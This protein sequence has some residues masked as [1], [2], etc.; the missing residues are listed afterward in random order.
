[1]KR[2]ILILIAV[3]SAVFINAAN[4]EKQYNK[5]IEIYDIADEAKEVAPMNTAA[6]WRAMLDN[7]ESCLKFLKDIKKNK[8]AEK[9][10]LNNTAQ[11]P[12][13]YPQYD[14]TIVGDL[15]GFC[16]T[17]LI[18]MGI[19]DLGIKCSLHV[20]SSDEAYAFTALTEDGFAMCLTTRLINKKGVTYETLMGYVAREFVHGALYH[21]TRGFYAQAK[22]DRKYAIIG[23]LAAGALVTTLALTADDQDHCHHRTYDSNCDTTVVNIENVTDLSARK[24]SFQYT[25]DQEFEAD[26][27]AYRFLEYLGNSDEFINGLRILGADYDAFYGENSNHPTIVTRID[28]L[29]Y[30]RKHPELGNTK[31]AKLR[32][33]R[34]QSEQS[35]R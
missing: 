5:I 24:Y 18:D 1:M 21:H 2:I 14:E 3:T 29:K 19:S 13:F 27:I 15:Q 25:R 10:A 20:V 8:G 16:D 17:L 23:S 34:E 12:R 35:L 31:N 28:F 9:E 6:F 30:V 33:K 22:A 4:I 7:N 11:L 32:K 26:L